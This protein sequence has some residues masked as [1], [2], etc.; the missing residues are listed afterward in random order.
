MRRVCVAIGVSRAE[1]LAPLRGAA[2]AAEH[3]GQ[4]A[5]RSGF[6]MKEDIQ[7]LTDRQTPI[8]ID[9]IAKTL[10]RLLPIGTKTDALLLHFAGHGLREDNTR[11]LWLPTNWRTEL[12]AIAVERLK[13]RL[14]DF[15]I[16]NITIISDACKALANDKDS[17]DLTADG[18]LGEGT[19]AGARP[20]F[21]RFDA[22]HDVETAFMIPGPTPAESRCL[23]SEAIIEAL[24][25][26][27]KA[28]DA[29]YPG[30]VTPGSLADYLSVRVA[31]LCTI[32][33]L[34][35][36]PESFTGRPADHL[37][38]FDK[39]QI[40]ANNIPNLPAW[41]PAPIDIKLVAPSI[42]PVSVLKG[43]GKAVFDPSSEGNLSTENNPEII[44]FDIAAALKG[45]GGFDLSTDA[46]DL[47]GIDLSTETID[48]AGDGE[49][50]IALGSGKIAGT[51]HHAQIVRGILGA[52]L[53]GTN[54]DIGA[55]E[56]QFR[57]PQASRAKLDS[58]ISA[59]GSNAEIKQA[60]LEALNR[61]E[62]HRPSVKA[63]SD[64]HAGLTEDKV[65]WL[66][67]RARGEVERS[68][69]ANHKEGR[70]RATAAGFLPSLIPTPGEAN[71]LFGGGG[72]QAVWSRAPV[73]RIADD[74]WLA[75]IVGASQQLV[76]EYEDGIFLPLVVYNGFATIA[77]RDARGTNGWLFRAH[78][79]DSKS[80]NKAIDILSRM[81][82]GSLSPSEADEVAALLRGS[83]HGNPVL[84]AICSYLY[85]Y[86][87]DLNGIRRM[88]LFYTNHGQPIPYDVT[89][90][91]EISTYWE[92]SDHVADLVAVG[93][94][95]VK[96]GRQDHANSTIDAAP[97]ALGLVGGLCPWLRQ[98]WDFLDKSTDHKTLLVQNL[99]DIRNHLLPETFT[100]FDH[101][102]GTI[103]T[104]FWEM[105]RW[106]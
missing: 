95:P 37:I 87:G 79:D 20:I 52:Q 106:Q 84:G 64:G 36:E 56:R 18:V 7:V 102:G 57:L 74:K 49:Q 23:F 71:L 78:D 24:W 62:T 47:T 33:Q 15:G 61:K 70:R 5:L 22:V 82:S 44:P 8:T 68:V 66:L 80:I 39:D 96:G 65:S 40:D 81:Q 21:D 69:V 32:Y 1:G 13:N 19:S 100:S 63:T 3:I 54:P 9:L 51:D 90:M 45:R 2:T 16:A 10:K 72:A 76:V 31:E 60:V 27:P 73:R 77:A 42:D 14:S 83:K 75:E 97:K 58:W 99:P 85:D 89:L 88:A 25:G 11:T 67:S 55:F 43:K 4:W 29:H 94:R 35:C 38:Y 26:T 98:G 101:E 86:T 28:I 93:K 46:I 41:P 30:K 50:T 103:L 92:G 105:E 59:I 104:K 34:K 6:A 12:R 17:S 91:G 53:G 48:L